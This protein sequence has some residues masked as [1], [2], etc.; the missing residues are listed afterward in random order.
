MNI[1]Y[2]FPLMAQMFADKKNAILISGN[3]RHLREIYFL[4]IHAP[5]FRKLK[6]GILSLRLIKAKMKNA[7]NQNIDYS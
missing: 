6:N 1:F 7:G 4:K 3:Q 5:F 2:Y